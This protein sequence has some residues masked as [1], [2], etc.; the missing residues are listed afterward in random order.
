MTRL[1]MA[2]LLEALF[3]N[4]LLFFVP[5]VLFAAYGTLSAARA[6]SEYSST[7]TVFIERSSFVND[8]TGLANG[9]TGYLSP[10]AFAGQELYGL[11][12]TDVF[13]ESVLVDAG[14][15]MEPPGQLRS[16]QLAIARASIAAFATG[17]NLLEVSATTSDPAVSER[18]SASTI[19][20]FIQFKVDLDIDESV[21]AAEFF[22]DLAISYTD[23]AEAARAELNAYVASVSAASIDD[24]TP[25]EQLEIDR[26]TDAETQAATRYQEALGNFE[27]A[28]LAELQAKIDI[29]QSFAIVDPPQVSTQADNGLTSQIV[30]VMLF[31]SV[32]A[33][34]AFAGPAVM[35]F[36]NQGILFEEELGDAVE[37]VAVVATVSKRDLEVALAVLPDRPPVSTIGSDPRDHMPG[38]PESGGTGD[39]STEPGTESGRWVRA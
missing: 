6:D 13:V 14:V 34:V 39:A 20:R 5:L 35:A 15:Q 11:L 37:V 33:V 27:A 4:K 7:G 25:E 3:R 36:L 8:L 32:G 18:L 19:E 30:L 10:A 23:D 29:E 21:A 9:F 28:R 2:R 22:A 16:V 31:T 24:L 26:L 12:Q 38:T 17:E 1:A